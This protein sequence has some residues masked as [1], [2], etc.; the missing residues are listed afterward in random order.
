MGKPR[1]GKKA[2]GLAA[3][4]WVGVKGSGAIR[5]LG[6]GGGVGPTP[7]PAR[8][9]APP[10]PFPALPPFGSL[11][12]RRPPVTALPQHSSSPSTQAKLLMTALLSFQR[13]TEAITL[14]PQF[15]KGTPAAVRRKRQHCCVGGCTPRRRGWKMLKD[16]EQ[17][18]PPAAGES[19]V[20][21][22]PGTMGLTHLFSPMAPVHC[23]AL[24][25]LHGFCA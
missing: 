13:S 14:A 8:P 19:P 2:N 16:V 3:T 17:P 4:Q 15:Y 18:F 6:S 12:T 7:S 1:K 11:G 10:R 21:G 23:S 25:W 5:G 20:R 9:T 22:R 24:D